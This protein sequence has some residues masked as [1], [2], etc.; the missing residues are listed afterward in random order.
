MFAG[1]SGLWVL[2][3]GPWPGV[4]WRHSNAECLR[5]LEIDNQL[6]LGRRPDQRS[7]S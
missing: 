5:G 4:G 1:V 3:H 6:I 2:A 7:S